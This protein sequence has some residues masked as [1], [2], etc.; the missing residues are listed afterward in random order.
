MTDPIAGRAATFRDD[1]KISV[2]AIA[3]V[4][5]RRRWQVL[6]LAAIGFAL[7]LASGLSKTR[8][9]ASSATF[10]PEQSQ[11]STSSLAIAA[12]Q[13]GFTIPSAGG[14]WGPSMYVELLR[15]RALLD[16]IALDTVIVAEENGRR[17]PLIDLLKIK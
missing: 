3:T 6:G 13:F 1:D 10:I 4:V 17:V 2:F 5:V 14:G 15:S 7:G 9:Y 16:P 11:G 12:S 8:V